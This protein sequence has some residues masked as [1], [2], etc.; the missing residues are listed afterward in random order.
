MTAQLFVPIEKGSRL[1]SQGAI[2]KCPKGH[3]RRIHCLSWA[4]LCCYRD[5]CDGK[6]Y[7]KGEYTIETQITVSE[8]G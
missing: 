3:S 5:G 2:I 1:R 6:E 4:N 8:N 7:Q